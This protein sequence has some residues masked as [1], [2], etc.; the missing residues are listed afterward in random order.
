MADL[1]GASC[2]KVGAV[3]PVS[4]IDGINVLH[5]VP[6][7]H[8]LSWYAGRPLLETLCTLGSHHNRSAR[9]RFSA[10]ALLNRPGAARIVGRVESGLL[11]PGQELVDQCSGARLQVTAIDRFGETDLPFA[12]PGDSVGLRFDGQSPPPGSILAPPAEP[13]SLGRVWNARVLSVAER[14]IAAGEACELRFASTAV[15]GRLTRI[16]HRWDSST[17]DELLCDDTIRFS[18]IAAIRLQLDRPAAADVIAD[19]PPTGRFML[20]DGR[21][22]AIAFGVIDS[23]VTSDEEGMGEL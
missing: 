14:V 15:T 23:I 18:Q 17:L 1:T 7:E 8:P 2:L 10:Q 5:P 12:G 19:C 9:L 16:Q 6:E 13:L 20:C 4:A 21:G 22:Q 3:V 11:H